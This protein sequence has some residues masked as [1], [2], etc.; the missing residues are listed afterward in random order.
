[1]G[2]RNLTFM[3]TLYILARYYSY[4][5][6]ISVRHQNWIEFKDGISF[7]THGFAPASGQT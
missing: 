3:P 6:D 2:S 1:M 7:I 5:T 4:M